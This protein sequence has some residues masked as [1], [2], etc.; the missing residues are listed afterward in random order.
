MYVCAFPYI[1][2]FRRNCATYIHTTILRADFN[3]RSSGFYACIPFYV[4]FIFSPSS[5]TYIYTC[6]SLYTY[7][8]TSIYTCLHP[9]LLTYLL[10]SHL[11]TYLLTSIH[12]YLQA[13][14]PFNIHPSAH[15][16]IHAYIHHRSTHLAIIGH[17]FYLVRLVI[18]LYVL[19]FFCTVMISSL[20]SSYWIGTFIPVS[21]SSSLAV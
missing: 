1:H 10:T 19:R 8:H 3:T 5:A 7:I 4:Y 13:Y 18:A 14:I 6:L 11:S 16:Y 21:V 2:G 9:Y 12:K 17:G 15:L 20:F